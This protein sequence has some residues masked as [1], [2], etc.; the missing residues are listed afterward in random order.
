MLQLIKRNQK[1]ALKNMK[2]ATEMSFFIL[3]AVKTLLCHEIVFKRIEP[4]QSKFAARHKITSRT[5]KKGTDKE[6][7]LN[8][9]FF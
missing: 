5:T 1:I 2:L 4:I 3:R 9:L 8:E 7:W 6:H